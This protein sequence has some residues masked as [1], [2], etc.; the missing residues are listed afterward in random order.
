MEKFSNKK[1]EMVFRF[2]P[3][4]IREKLLE[5]RELIFSTAGKIEGGGPILETIKWGDPSYA[6][7]KGS[8]IRLGLKASSTEHYRMFFHCQTTLVKTYRQLYPDCFVFEGN[9][10]IVFH[11]DE[12]IPLQELSHCIQLALTYHQIKHLPLLGAG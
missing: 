6:V 10:A 7:S 2:Y 9:R 1:I 8:P 3:D 4:S 5:L 12:P 11:L